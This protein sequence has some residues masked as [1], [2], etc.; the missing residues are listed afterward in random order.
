MMVGGEDELSRSAEPLVAPY[1][2]AF[3][4]RSV[5]SGQLTKMVNQIAIAG[6][7]EGLSEALHFA[8]RDLDRAVI[9]AIAKGAAQS[10]QIDHR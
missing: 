9:D 7:L 10:W 6:L 5:G 8:A 3:A 2:R 1:A 4:A